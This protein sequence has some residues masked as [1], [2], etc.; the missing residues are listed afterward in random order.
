MIQK[1][2]KTIQSLLSD[3]KFDVGSGYIERRGV[4]LENENYTIQIDPYPTD[5]IRPAVGKGLFDLLMTIFPLDGDRTGLSNLKLE[6]M[7]QNSAKKITAKTNKRGQIWFRDVPAGEKYR[8]QVKVPLLVKLLSW[9]RAIYDEIKKLF[10]WPKHGNVNTD[11]TQQSIG[12]DVLA[13]EVSWAIPAVLVLAISL[14]IVLWPSSSPSPNQIDTINQIILA[15]KTVEME[16][17]LRGSKFRWEKTPASVSAFSSNGPPSQAAK[18]FGAGL[19]TARESLLGQLT[20]PQP[21]LPPPAFESWLETE[22][23]NRFELGRWTFLLWTASQFPDEMPQT[24]WE[25]QKKILAQFKAEFEQQKTDQAKEVI[26]QLENLKIEQLL[27]KLPDE[28]E[29]YDDLGANLKDLMSFLAPPPM[30]TVQ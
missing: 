10:Q 22:W 19:L 3:F 9:I 8:I 20:L 2:L 24:F 12:S 29:S 15:Q 28:P 23:A 17:E 18:A 13:W 1:K 21:L 27:N 26:F 11:N 6:L 7:G 5:K 16:K 4:Y 25:E 30:E 14:T